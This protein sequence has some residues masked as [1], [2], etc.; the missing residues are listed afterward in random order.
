MPLIYVTGFLLIS[1]VGS[2]QY[3]RQSFGV[4]LS[5]NLFAIILVTYLCGL[6]GYLAAGVWFLRALAAFDLGWC[7]YHGVQI[8]RKKHAWD[9]PVWEAAFLILSL[10]ALWFV[11]RGAPAKG[12]SP[13]RRL[14][15]CA[16]GRCRPHELEMASCRAGSGGKMARGGFAGRCVQGFDRQGVRIPRRCDPGVF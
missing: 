11:V 6:A 5:L 12:F 15:A 4:C 8:L 1:T 10:S 13:A 14:L 9:L 3:T 2:M 16:C 7:G